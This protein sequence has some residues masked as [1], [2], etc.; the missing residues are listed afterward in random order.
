MNEIIASIKEKLEF[1]VIAGWSGGYL[2]SVEPDD[3]FS[4]NLFE[5]IDN[6]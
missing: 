6:E 5:I 4:C 3:D 2:D 1:N